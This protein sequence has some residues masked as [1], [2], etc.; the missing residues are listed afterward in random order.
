MNYIKGAGLLLFLLAVLTACGSSD[1]E[2]EKEGSSQSMESATAWT[3]EGSVIEG[4]IEKNTESLDIDVSNIWPVKDTIDGTEEWI[5]DEKTDLYPSQYNEKYAEADGVIY[6][7]SNVPVRY[8]DKRTYIWG[9]LCDR[10]NCNHT[11]EEDCFAWFGGGK[12]GQFYNGKLYT[13][14]EELSGSTEGDTWQY[15]YSLY[16]TDVVSMTRE[17]VQTLVT[18]LRGADEPFINGFYFLIHR[19]YLY[20]WYRLTMSETN[21]YE[22]GSNY[23][24]RMPLGGSSESVECIYQIKRNTGSNLFLKPYGN[25]LYFSDGEGDGWTGNLYR[26]NT[27]EKQVE[28][29]PVE[30][31]VYNNEFWV[32]GDSLYYDGPEEM[33]KIKEF[34]L[35]DKT[36][37]VV[38][39]SD[40]ETG[41]SMEGLYY[42]GDF[43][44]IAYRSKQGAGDDWMV[45]DREFNQLGTIQ[46]QDSDRVME[47][48]LFLRDVILIRGTDGAM[49]WIDKSK[50]ADGDFTVH[51]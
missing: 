3:A 22:N 21:P 4:N 18:V 49:Q 15:R 23:I 1:E 16:E 33:G 32:E 29:I 13:I 2:P 8:F 30:G 39:D 26:I 37:K 36:T 44:Y 12:G 7:L 11:R 6:D 28:K 10:P 19:G 9:V 24:Y 35:V 50:M 41:K 46:N 40:K 27:T 47:I 51:D 20:Y 34:S 14:E 17:K 31:I 43:W 25:N 38:F 42:D 45:F 5:Y 48:K